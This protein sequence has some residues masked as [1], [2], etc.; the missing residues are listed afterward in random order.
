M[1]N[2]SFNANFG[3]GKYFFTSMNLYHDDAYFDL[4]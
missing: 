2:Y 1:R 3:T 4:I